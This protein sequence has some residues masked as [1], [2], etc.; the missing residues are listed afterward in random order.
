M[1][2]NKPIKPMLLQASDSVK[3]ESDFISQL[4]YDGFRVIIHYDNGLTRAFTREGTEITASFPELSKIRL[5]V[6]S[7]ILDGECICLMGNNP[8]KPCWEDAMTRFKAKKELLIKRLTISMPA[9][10]IIW[11]ILYLNGQSLLKTALLERLDLLERS[12]S[13]S[14]VIS[15]TKS[16]ED[17][18]TLFDQAKSLGLEGIVQKNTREGYNSFYHLDSRPKNVWYK[19]KAYLYLDNVSVSAISRKKFGWSLS[20]GE[21]YVGILE[22]PPSAVAREQFFRIAKQII[23]YQTDDW[24]YLDPLIT[25]KV[26]F[27]CY[28]KDGKL[29]SPSFIELNA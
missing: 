20:V 13:P 24:I 10:F 8:P 28:T 15:I 16:Y 5:P 29:R 2:L 1:N 27:Q 26:K 11:D 9:H 12:V 25:C 17:G 22:F 19:V 4:K 21:K 6:L 3:L 18:K 7:A 23:R 14:D